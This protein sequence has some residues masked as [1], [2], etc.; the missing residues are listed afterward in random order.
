MTIVER[1]TCY[2]Q[3]DFKTGRLDKFNHAAVG[4]NVRLFSHR[5]YHAVLKKKLWMKLFIMS[6]ALLEGINK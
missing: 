4:P 3:G 6:N 5:T 2:I 1:T